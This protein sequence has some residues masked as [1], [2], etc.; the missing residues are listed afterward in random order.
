MRKSTRNLPAHSLRGPSSGDRWIYRESNGVMKGCPASVRLSKGIEEESSIYAAEGTAAHWISQIAR[1]QNQ[2]AS[3]FLGYTHKKEMTNPQGGSFICDRE[4]AEGVQTFLDYVNNIPCTAAA[5]EEKLTYFKWVPDDGFG[6]ADDIRI[7][8]KNGI[9]HITD[10]KYG[11]G[12]QVFAT[13]NIQLLLY[14][15]GVFETYGLIYEFD[16]F[17]LNI[18]QPRL[19]HVDEWEVSLDDLLAWGENVVKP[20]AEI[21]DKP[22]APV[23]PGIWCRWC[24]ARKRCR[25]RILWVLTMSDIETEIINN[26]ELAQLYDHVDSVR[27]LCNDIEELALSEAT[28]TAGAIPGHKIVEGRSNRQW[29]D[30]KEIKRAML[31]EG[32]DSTDIVTEKLISVAQFEKLAGK[33]S[34]L[35]TE[36]YVNKPP[37]APTLVPETD[38]RPALGTDVD[39]EFA[40]FDEPESLEDLF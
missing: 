33:K 29:K 38:K 30:E 34:E 6:T 27:K 18:S 31:N 3:A 19:D 20:A 37:G 15:L 11:K 35:L 2:P 39:E 28:K 32:F 24:P 12:V 36:D 23:N 13:D 16:R 10:L 22:D 9:C 5:F 4:M 21:T 7:D 40:D 25:K 1:E 17:S 14:A 26:Y 8:E